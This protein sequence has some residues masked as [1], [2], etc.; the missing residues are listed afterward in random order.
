LEG[1]FFGRPFCCRARR[2]TSS[3]AA[4][5]VVVPTHHIDV[6]I[7][8][9]GGTSRSNGRHV[10]GK[11]RPLFGAADIA[12][13]LD[14]GGPRS[15][16]KGKLGVPKRWLGKHPTQEHRVERAGGVALGVTERL[17]WSPGRRAW[18]DGQRDSLSARLKNKKES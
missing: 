10:V 7:N 3:F 4:V 5:V 8:G 1:A 11:S 12:T 9:S 2:M 18:S 14:H 15:F 13:K 17:D 16:K 6:P